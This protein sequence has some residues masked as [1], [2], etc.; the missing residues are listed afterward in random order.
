[1]LRRN[2]VAIGFLLPA[3]V[4]LSV[5]IVYPTIFTFVS[6]FY[7]HDGFSWSKGFGLLVASPQRGGGHIIATR[8][9]RWELLQT[10]EQ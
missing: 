8:R 3:A 5:W 7:G 10:A 9:K 1:M 4:M 6:S 2:A